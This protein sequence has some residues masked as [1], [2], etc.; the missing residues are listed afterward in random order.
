MSDAEDRIKNFLN[1]WD[2]HYTNF[3]ITPEEDHCDPTHPE[4][5]F[6]LHDDPDV[7]VAEYTPEL[8]KLAASDI[9]FVLADLES[10]RALAHR[11][12]ERLTA[13]ED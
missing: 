3:A 7:L 6:H 8:H 9:R 10:W 12:R 4:E 13:W 1:W 2:T 11:T 5:F